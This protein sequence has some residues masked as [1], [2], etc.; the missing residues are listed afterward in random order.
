MLLLD[1]M[2]WGEVVEVVD[3][4][5]RP[6]SLGAQ[7]FTPLTLSLPPGHYRVTFRNPNFPRPVAVDAEVL[8][9]GTVKSVAELGRIDE[10]E[11][12]HGL[13]W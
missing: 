7:R 1:A 8:S 13:G 5:G 10:Q 3:R 6:Q 9:G 12:F 11:F 4:E 2:P